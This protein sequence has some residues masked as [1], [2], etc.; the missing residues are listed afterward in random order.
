[1]STKICHVLYPGG[2]KPV[3][4][5]HIA[6]MNKYLNSK[7]YAVK[8]TV[9]ISRSP[10]EGISAE[11]SKW[12]LEQVFRGN[13]NVNIIISPDA[14]PIK[15]V[16]DMI[17]TKAFGDGIYA[18][19]ASA[20][21]TDIKRAEDIVDKFAEGGKYYTPGVKVIFFPINPEPI[22]YLGRTDLYTDTP[23][24]ST[25]VRNDIRNGRYDM[26]RTA[27][28]PLL[29][30]P[31]IISEDILKT[32]YGM[33]SKELLPIGEQSLN[34]SLK[35]SLLD[36]SFYENRVLNEG[37]AAGHMSHPY[38]YPELTFRDLKTLIHDLF[39]G[40]ITDVTE[41]LDGQNLFASVDE[42]GN[43]IFARNE[44]TLKEQPWYLEDVMY[45]PKWIGTPSVQH[46]FTN[47]ALTIDKIFKNIPKAV[48][49]FNY[50]DKADGIRYRYWLNLEIIDTENF[51][52]VPYAD[53]KVSF[54]RFVVTCFDYSEIDKISKPEE[55]ANSPDWDKF[56]M[57][58][59]QN[60][61]KMAVLQKAIDKTTRTVF[62][63]QITPEVIFKKLQDG[64]VK[65]QKYYQ[66]ID[67]LL[68]KI[69]MS[70][71]LTIREYKALRMIDYVT[72]SKELYWLDGE[73]LDA[74][75]D[76]WVDN[77]KKPSITTI[78]KTCKLSNQMLMSKE[79]YSILNTFDKDYSKD[80][81]KIIMKPLDTLFI[82]VGTEVLKRMEGFSNQGRE[83]E[84]QAKLR[85]TL[86]DI[87]D[88]VE[89][90]GN[91]Q[92]KKKLENQLAR[93]ADIDNEV[94]STEGIVLKWHGRIM[95]IT[96][97]FAPIN[98]IMSFEN[99][100]ILDDKK[101]REEKN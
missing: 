13:H 89:S 101:K 60:K 98:Q 58:E 28:T 51:N 38:D 79:Q 50:D 31:R 69:G 45:N 53:S 70:D 41:K 57:D 73:V 62:K 25:T 33:I 99:R 35:E 61:E 20:K 86:S 54:H 27:Y 26:F 85:K 75:I 7:E 92:Q 81:I 84:V 65:A 80:A 63:A 40:S 5:G 82:K 21:G 11:S 12:F 29:Q 43:T 88:A 49:F 2:F 9:V 95:K 68:D 17:G 100:K 64:E 76:R 6:L 56:N 22:T 74:M 91:E 34:S 23:I 18:M 67:K 24:S 1:M 93:L 66:Y 8:L 48:E 3:H 59:E 96:G 15:T 16:Y 44:K 42:H 14:S 77:T 39:A 83:K 46:A 71:K 30:N 37:G 55:D 97:L 4:Y 78:G 10:R 52:V 19:G 72:N 90:N 36:N 32:Y 87:K 47:A 94:C